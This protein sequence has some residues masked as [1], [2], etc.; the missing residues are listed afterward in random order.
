MTDF[1]AKHEP[2]RVPTVRTLGLPHH[3]APQYVPSK[4]IL[5]KREHMQSKDLNLEIHPLADRCLLQADKKS[6]FQ[7]MRNLRSIS[8]SHKWS[9][10][11]Y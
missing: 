5:R 11:S 10:K 4:K 6:P 7:F 9:P 2:N 8:E 3:T 1:S